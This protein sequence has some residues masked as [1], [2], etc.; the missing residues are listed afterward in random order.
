MSLVLALM[1]IQKLWP[2]V[3]LKNSPVPCPA[4]VVVTL[5]SITPVTRLTSD[6]ERSSSDMSLLMVL[7]SCGQP[8]QSSEPSTAMNTASVDPTVTGP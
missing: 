3:P 2:G 6:A 7:R 5:P 4:V 8:A 1:R